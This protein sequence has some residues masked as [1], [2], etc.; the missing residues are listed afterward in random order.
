M[1]RDINLVNLSTAQ[2]QSLRQKVNIDS[3]F[4][5]FQG[6]IDYSLLVGIEHITNKSQFLS[7]HNN[8][9]PNI[10]VSEV[11]DNNY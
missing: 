6:L 8:Y 4:L 3:I 11:I 2:I 7:I 1:N 9:G 10:Y 5:K